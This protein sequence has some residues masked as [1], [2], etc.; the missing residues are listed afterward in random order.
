MGKVVCLSW[1]SKRQ[2]SEDVSFIE[3]CKCEAMLKEYCLW[4]ESLKFLF[5]AVASSKIKYWR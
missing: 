1:M 5:E 3:V 2:R 4:I